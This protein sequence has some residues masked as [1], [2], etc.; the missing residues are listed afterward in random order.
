MTVGSDGSKVGTTGKDL[1]FSTSM[2]I[3]TFPY[4]KP[5]VSAWGPWGPQKKFHPEVVASTDPR[6][7]PLM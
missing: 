4:E 7:I 1:A 5:G 3:A 2:K 6:R